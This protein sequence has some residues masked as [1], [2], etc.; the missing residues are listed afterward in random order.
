VFT[1]RPVLGTRGV[2]ARSVC[3]SVI[4]TPAVQVTYVLRLNPTRGLFCAWGFLYFDKIQVTIKG[5][6]SVLHYISSDRKKVFKWNVVKSETNLD[7]V[8]IKAHII[9]RPTA[10]RLIKWM[11]GFGE[12]FAGFVRLGF[13]RCH[14][15]PSFGRRPLPSQQL[16]SSRQLTSFQLYWLN[17]RASTCAL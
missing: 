1:E 5:P 4:S 13:R 7:R 12:V 10:D 3:S 2:N 17:S 8:M 9:S 6:M 14:W 11:L 15:F 16:H